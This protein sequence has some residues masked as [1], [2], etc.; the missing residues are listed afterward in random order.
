MRLALCCAA[1]AASPVLA[2]CPT[3]ADLESGIVFTTDTGETDTYTSRPNGIVQIDA[4]SP[5]NVTYR[6]LLGKGI[7]VLQLSD[8]EN[9]Q[10]LSDSIVSTS[11][12]MAA[13]E[14][15]V[16]EPGTRW[17]VD[18]MI[19]AYGDIYPETQ[20]QTYGQMTAYTVGDCTF[21][22]IPAKFRYES[23]GFTINEDIIYLPDLGL[24]LLV[25]YEDT[26]APR[27]DYAYVAVTV[28]Q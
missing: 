5:E 6:T 4:L 11:Y 15:P 1:L 2:D 19:N 28:A 25:A 12:P 17:R 22:A 16:P 14:L 7:H 24:S 13:A 3:G 20:T 21:D 8:L 18:T 10:V 9:G 26:D 23:D 27:E